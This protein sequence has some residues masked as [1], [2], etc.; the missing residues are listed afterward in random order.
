MP[1]EP[2]QPIPSHSHQRGYNRRSTMTDRELVDLALEGSE[3]AVRHLYER[4][5]PR[6]YAVVRRLA[7]GDDTLAEDWAQDAWLS[8]IRALPTFRGKAKFSTWLHRIAVN[9]ALQG[10][11]RH[12]RRGGREFPI[13]DSLGD[14]QPTDR[15]LLRIGLEAALDQLPPGMREVLILYDIEGFTHDG[16]AAKLGIAS[17]TSK[18]QLY[19]ARARMRELLSA[20]D[21]G[22]ATD[23]PETRASGEKGVRT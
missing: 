11:R 1:F 3:A 23:E 9:S 16:I 14:T 2:R 17:G 21:R 7:R 10:L 20:R 12:E 19:K 6:V 18:S 13:L 5:A 4:H 15:P 22:R 8:A